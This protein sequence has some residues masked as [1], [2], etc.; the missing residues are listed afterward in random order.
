MV[1]TTCKY[2]STVLQRY[3]V[4]NFNSN[5]IWFLKQRK[6]EILERN[7]QASITAA[8]AASVGGGSGGQGSSSSSASAITSPSDTSQQD[9]PDDK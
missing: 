5:W 2:N 4:S 9:A 8:A 1:L 7:K 6:K 3:H